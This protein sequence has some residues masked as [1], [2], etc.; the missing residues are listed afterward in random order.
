MCQHIE[1]KGNRWYYRRRIPQ[2][3]RE[4]HRDPQSKKAPEQVYFSLKTADKA[5]AS[6]LAVSHTRR[7]DALWKAHREGNVDPKISMAQLQAAGL[8]PGDGAKYPDLDPVTDFIDDLFDRRFDQWEEPSEPSRQAMMTRDMLMTGNVPKTLSDARDKHIE[9]GKRSKEP[10]QVQ[11]FE[12]AWAILL[13]VTGDITL[14]NLTRDHA[15]RFVRKVITRGKGPNG[16]GPATVERYLKQVS[17]VI[18][19]AIREFELSMNNPFVGV[20]IPNKAEGQRKP[21][22][23]FTSNEIKTIQERC[24]DK[25]DQRRWAIAMISDTGGRVANVVEIAGQRAPGM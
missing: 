1:P 25:N 3:C 4:L 10:K 11:Q 24:R 9:L 17:P 20:V 18:T 6:K 16:N 23:S 7:F 14:N 12:R 21:R 8:S 2:D 13:E 15:N 5:E 22:E 19:T